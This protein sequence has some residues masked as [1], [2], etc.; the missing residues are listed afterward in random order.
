MH[1]LPVQSE[2]LPYMCLAWLIIYTGLHLGNLYYGCNSLV[3]KIA[4][5]KNKYIEQ[6][7]IFKMC[8]ISFGLQWIWYAEGEQKISTQIQNSI[9]VTLYINLPF[10]ARRSS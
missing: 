4:S 9:V 5:S 2:L 7:I 6:Y 3:S 10:F 8:T 1:V